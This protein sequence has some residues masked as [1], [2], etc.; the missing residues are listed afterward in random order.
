MTL[1]DPTAKPVET[2]PTVYRFRLT[3]GAGET[4]KFPVTAHGMVYSSWQL[5]NSDDNGLAT[6]FQQADNSPQFQAAIQP[7]LDARRKV[8]DA[9]TAVNQVEARLKSLHAEEERQ[10]ANITA[11]NNADKGSRDRFVHDLNTTE[12]EIKAANTDLAARTAA[13]DAAKADL[14]NRIETLQFSQTV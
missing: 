5:T 1:D 7:I 13:L 14:A 10:R 3:V 8:A 6:I 11:L 12:D 2:T 9:Q 4:V